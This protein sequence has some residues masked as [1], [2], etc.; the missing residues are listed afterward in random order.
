MDATEI[1]RESIDGVEYEYRLRIYSIDND[2]YLTGH[3]YYKTL[4]APVEQA[5]PANRNE[6]VLQIK[7][8]AEMVFNRLRK[9]ADEIGLP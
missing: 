4:S 6:S 5:R 2:R 9:E 1:I 3:V 7:M 8:H